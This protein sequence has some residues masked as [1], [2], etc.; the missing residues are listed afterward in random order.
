MHPGKDRTVEEHQRDADSQPENKID[1]QRQRI[2]FSNPFAVAAAE[3]LGDQ[4]RHRQRDHAE[5][6]DQNIDDLIGIADRRDGV[7][8]HLAH[9]H[10]VDIAD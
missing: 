8:R 10:L 4:N 9:H 6:N 1:K 2:G 7:L 3:I 5:R